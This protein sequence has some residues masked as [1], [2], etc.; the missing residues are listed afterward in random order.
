M[1]QIREELS[2]LTNRQYT[3][4]VKCIR[5]RTELSANFFQLGGLTLMQIIRILLGDI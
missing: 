5:S 1:R 3:L 2:V 4:G